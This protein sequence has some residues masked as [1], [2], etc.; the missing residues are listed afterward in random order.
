MITDYSVI[1]IN[2]NLFQDKKQMLT[3]KK[4]NVQKFIHFK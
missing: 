3:Q 1:Y 2:L 4:T